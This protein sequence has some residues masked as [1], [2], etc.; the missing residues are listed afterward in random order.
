VS[1]PF[2]SFWQNPNLQWLNTEFDRIARSTE[3]G[4]I[5]MGGIIPRIS[6]PIKPLENP[7]LELKLDHPRIAIHQVLRQVT[8][9]SFTRIF[10][11]EDELAFPRIRKINA[12]IWDCPLRNRDHRPPTEPS[13]RKDHFIV[14]YHTVKEEVEFERRQLKFTGNPSPKIQKPIDHRNIFNHSPTAKPGQFN[15]DRWSENR[16]LGSES[17]PSWGEISL[18]RR[19]STLGEI[20][21]KARQR[22][23]AIMRRTSESG[24]GL[25]SDSG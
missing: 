7:A 24:A 8:P 18:N 14:Q 1:L 5:G 6:N 12:R 13:L 9:A 10:D 11:I 4:L 16:K 17:A 25:K 3:K 22:G 19:E 21:P 23:V 20:S 15:R 2:P